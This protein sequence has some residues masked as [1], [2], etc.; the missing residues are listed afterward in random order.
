MGFKT[1]PL[2]ITVHGKV[3]AY[4]LT[5]EQLER[6]LSR[7]RQAGRTEARRATIRGSIKLLR[8]LEEGSAEARRTL[9]ESAARTAEALT[10]G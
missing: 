2:G 5:G 1:F 3:T 4:L 8:P 6:M 9:L 10:R 7:A